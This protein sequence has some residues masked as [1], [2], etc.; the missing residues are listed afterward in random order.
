MLVLL[1][2]WSSS[3]SRNASGIADYPEVDFRKIVTD[4]L[5]VSG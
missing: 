5:A 3:M 1:A 2:N 4:L